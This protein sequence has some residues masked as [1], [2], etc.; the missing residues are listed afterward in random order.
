MLRRASRRACGQHGYLATELWPC[1][2]MLGPPGLGPPGFRL[3]ACVVCACVV[4]LL[5]DVPPLFLAC[6]GE[7]VTALCCAPCQAAIAA[8]RP[9][10]ALVGAASRAG[11][12][13]EIRV[14]SRTQVGRRGEDRGSSL[15]P[16]ARGAALPL[17]RDGSRPERSA[18]CMGHHTI[19]LRPAVY[20]NG[21]RH[22]F[23]AVHTRAGLDRGMIAE[24]RTIARVVSP[25]SVRRVLF[26]TKNA[27]D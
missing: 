4:T 13:G 26:S 20:F 12:W 18:A 3:C 10:L 17:L 19:A 21:W 8:T 9:R 7:K 11:R 1:V 27:V 16:S 5:L 15:G 23:V 2:V 14:A 6:C 25:S 24:A 22:V